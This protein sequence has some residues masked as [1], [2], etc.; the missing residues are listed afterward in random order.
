[1]I[2]YRVLS[3]L[4]SYPEQELIDALPEIEA[5]LAPTP[6][7]RAQLGPLLEHLRTTK[8]IRLQEEYVAEFDR[9][10]RQSLYLFEHIHGESRER[11]D[12]LLDLLREY[13]RH[14][15]EP[16]DEVGS[17]RETPDYLPLFLEFLAQRP[18]EEAA[19]LLGDAVNVIAL[20]GSR[21]A[22]RENP[23][24]AVFTVLQ[25]MSPVKAQPM[26]D[27]PARDMDTLLD[28]IG[29]GNDGSEPLLKPDNGMVQTVKFYR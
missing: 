25:E 10:R 21:L 9:S 2:I 20:V 29:P 15:F 28:T 11:G 5:A 17:P 18:P 27:A 22:E 3:A 23:Y 12:A 24:A 19:R 26:E 1:M 16:C 8:L 13:Q 6:R 7:I 4:L 14:G